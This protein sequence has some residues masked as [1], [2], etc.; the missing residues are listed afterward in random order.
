M[1]LNLDLNNFPLSC[2][3]A[4]VNNQ[5]K[6]FYAFHSMNALIEVTKQ[7]TEIRENTHKCIPLIES[8]K[9]GNIEIK[10]FATFHPDVEITVM[11]A[12]YTSIVDDLEKEGYTNLRSNYN[13]GEFTLKT[14]VLQMYADAYPRLFVLAVS[15]R[16]EKVVLGIFETMQDGKA[17]IKKTYGSDTKKVLLR[18][19]DNDLTTKYHAENGVKLK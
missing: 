5:D 9:S 16:R 2:V 12:E 10:V 17:W 14:E 4:F 1:P 19:C 8:Y 6:S 7:I 13:A 15:K 3:F 11:K 18:F